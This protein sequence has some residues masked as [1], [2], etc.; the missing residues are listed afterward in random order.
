MQVKKHRYHDL[1][2]HTT[3]PG[4]KTL[5]IRSNEDISTLSFILKVLL[6]LFSTHINSGSHYRQQNRNDG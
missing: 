3:C 2:P 4:S 1:I 6:K 5:Q